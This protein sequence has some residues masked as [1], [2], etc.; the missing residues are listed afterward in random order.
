MTVRKHLCDGL[1]KDLR[2]AAAG[3]AVKHERLRLRR[4]SDGFRHG[5]KRDRLLVR[6]LK[7]LR[8]HEL[9]AF[10]R[11]AL[12]AHLAARDPACLEQWFEHRGRTRYVLTDLAQRRL[13]FEAAQHI[14]HTRLHRRFAAQLLE[15]VRR[16]FFH[17]AEMAVGDETAWFLTHRLRQH[18]AQHRVRGNEVIFRDPAC[19]LQQRWREHRPLTDQGRD[20]LQPA[21][22]G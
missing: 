9:L 6:E 13:A 18:R 4:V 10:I 11:I 19:Q 12:H 14:E 3:D 17:E 1:Q 20:F 2:F 8:G 7:R 5:L 22:M 16:R 15:N 21:A